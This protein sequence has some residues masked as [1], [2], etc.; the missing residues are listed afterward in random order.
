MD[1]ILSNRNFQLGAVLSVL[2]VVSFLRKGKTLIT[3][4]WCIKNFLKVLIITF[5]ISRVG[6]SIEIALAMSVFFLSSIEYFRKKEGFENINTETRNIEVS[7]PFT[8]LAQSNPSVSTSMPNPTVSTSMPN[9]TVSTSIPNNPNTVQTSGD[10]KSVGGVITSALNTSSDVNNS[11]SS[12]STFSLAGLLKSSEPTKEKVLVV[13]S[14]SMPDLVISDPS[15]FIATLIIGKALLDEN[16]ACRTS[17]SVSEI[18]FTE[19]KYL[20][21]I[22]NEKD[23]FYKLDPSLIDVEQ[24]QPKVFKSYNLI[25]AKGYKLVVFKTNGSKVSFTATATEN[26][27]FK[28][29]QQ[30]FNALKDIDSIELSKL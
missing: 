9:Q 3:K 23:T 14:P 1:N 4:S 21:S 26:G 10:V 7:N 15:K 19:A 29:S 16:N 2:L 12:E 18:P 25:V 8:A 22:P 6:Y 17:K 30:I 5:F 13:C 24:I 27:V 11:Q 28:D 20:K